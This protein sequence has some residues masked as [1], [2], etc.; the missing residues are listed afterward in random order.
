MSELPFLVVHGAVVA[1]V[2][3]AATVAVAFIVA[4]VVRRPIERIATRKRVATYRKDVGK[5]AAAPIA[6]VRGTL[7]GDAT[8]LTASAV[9]GAALHLHSGT[10]A[11]EVEGDRVVL[12]GDIEVV[13]GTSGAA[14]WRHVPP[15]TPAA[16]A[17]RTRA[18]KD[19]DAPPG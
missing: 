2:V 12:S 9:R 17:A 6:H 5:L 1:K 4:R 8:T 13:R 19:S 3:V 18:A 14:G 15:G 7:R 10:I 11:V 16:L